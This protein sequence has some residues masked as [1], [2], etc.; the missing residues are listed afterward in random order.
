MGRWA[1]E[2]YKPVQA[3]LLVESEAARVEMR[4][5]RGPRGY[6]GGLIIVGSPER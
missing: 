6:N 4:S 3:Y 2:A 1:D 5:P